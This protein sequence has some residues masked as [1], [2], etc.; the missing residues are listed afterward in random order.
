MKML[1]KYIN[2][3]N[4]NITNNNNDNITKNINNID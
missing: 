3:D 4:D 2:N 1:W